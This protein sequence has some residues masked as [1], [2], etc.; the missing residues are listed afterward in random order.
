MRL[1]ALQAY[2]DYHIESVTPRPTD[3]LDELEDRLFRGSPTNGKN[4]R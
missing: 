2:A 3:V 4:V 1:D